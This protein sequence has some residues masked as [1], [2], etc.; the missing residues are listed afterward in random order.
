[1]LLQVA[2]YGLLRSGGAPGRPLALALWSLAA[3]VWL[4]AVF[5]PYYFFLVVAGLVWFALPG[6]RRRTLICAAAPL[7]LVVALLAKNVAVFGLWGTSSWGGN[8]LHRVAMAHAPRREVENL[9]K[10]GELSPLSLEWEFSSPLRYIAILH[11]T[12]PHWRVPALDEPGKTFLAPESKISSGN[13]NHWAYLAA[14]RVYLH[15]ALRIIRRFPGAYFERVV[16]NWH[17]F[18]QSVARDGFL[19]TN[20]ATVPRLSTVA[21]WCESLL[22]WL[23]PPGAA[24]ALEALFRRRG[25]RGERLFLGFLLGTVAWSGALSLLAESGE[26]NRFRYHMMGLALLL[27]CYTARRLWIS[28]RSRRRRP[29]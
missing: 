17:K 23:F 19:R 7:A 15:D 28:V 29:A 8:S 11:L 18:L 25:P 2:V 5:H 13:Y 12:N 4:R 27:A 9:V 6:E 3:L 1:M 22:L 20:R 26:N 16:W 21:E 14:S 24:L 10:A